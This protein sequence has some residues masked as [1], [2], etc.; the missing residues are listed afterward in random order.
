MAVFTT[1]N[2]CFNP[3]HVVS[4]WN[5]H[6]DWRICLFCSYGFVTALTNTCGL[7]GQSGHSGYYDLSGSC[8]D[9]GHS[10]YCS[11]KRRKQRRRR[12]TLVYQI[13][14][15]HASFWYSSN[16]N[17]SNYN[18]LAQSRWTFR[19]SKGHHSAYLIQPPTFL[20]RQWM[21]FSSN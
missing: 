17:G 15:P 11:T 21:E 18:H 4:H 14:Q 9:P 16:W 12:S 1:I 19:M 20:D 10:S 7:P 6:W 5:C 3:A 2:F 13:Y 8:N